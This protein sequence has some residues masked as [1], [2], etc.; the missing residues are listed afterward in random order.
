[1]KLLQHPFFVVGMQQVGPG[2]Q[3]VRKVLP[4]V[5]AQHSPELVAPF[6]LDHHALFI[7]VHSP[8]AR[9]EHLVNGIERSGFA[10]QCGIQ[11]IN[12]FELTDLRSFQF[13]DKQHIRDN[14][15]NGDN[16]LLRILGG[17]TRKA[18][19]SGEKE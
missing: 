8:S 10:L 17:E 6:D 1:M 11:S 18:M 13:A 15:N 2:F 7:K 19:F 14:A 16:D 12:V 4:A 3:N 5:V 9:H